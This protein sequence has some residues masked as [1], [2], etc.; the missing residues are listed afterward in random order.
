M[1]NKEWKSYDE[2]CNG[3]KKFCVTVMQKFVGNKL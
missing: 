1:Q 2:M 3:Y